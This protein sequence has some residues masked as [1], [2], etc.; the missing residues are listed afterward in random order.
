ML[1]ACVRASSLATVRQ[2]FHHLCD[3]AVPVHPLSPPLP[4][5]SPLPLPPPLPPVPLQVGILDEAGP[6]GEVAEEEVKTEDH[7]VS[8]TV[9]ALLEEGKRE[10]FGS[11]LVLP[12]ARLRAVREVIAG[13]FEE[14]LQKKPFYTLTTVSAT[15]HFST[16]KVY[17]IC[18][19]IIEW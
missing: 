2:N 9:I 11:V 4:F 17:N 5:P 7:R 10:L 3:P 15:I 19:C 14:K 6:S 16:V 18:S 8:K 1:Y 12:N 13:T